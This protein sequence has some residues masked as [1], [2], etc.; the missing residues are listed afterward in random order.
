MANFE[1][2]VISKGQR[3]TLRDLKGL[4]RGGP[5][6]TSAG[7]KKWIEEARERSTPAGPRRGLER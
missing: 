5:L 3:E 2:K 6:V 7:V 1:A 4:I